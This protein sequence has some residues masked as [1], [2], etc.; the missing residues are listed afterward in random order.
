MTRHSQA[1]PDATYSGRRMGRRAALSALFGSTVEYFDFTLFAT[2]SALVFGTVFFAPL[3]PAG[4]LLAS[5]ATFGVAYVTRPLGAILFGTL[6]DRL[7]RKR[8][9]MMTLLAM[10]TAT[11]LIG[12][13][14]SFDTI[15]VAAPI[16]L[17]ILRLLQ[18]LS[19]GGEQAGSNALS[20]EHAPTAKRG[21]YTSWTMQGTTLGTLLASLSFLAV[22]APGVD[23]LLAWAWRIPFLMAGP[24]LLIVL[25]IRRGVDET[26]AF[27][28]AKKNQVVDKFPLTTVLR[29]HWKSVL[30]VIACSLLAVGGSTFAVYVL[31]YATGTV[32]IPAGTMLYVP[33]VVGVAGLLSQPLWA[34]LSDRVGRRVVFTGSMVATA[35][36]WLPYF[37]VVSTGNIPA[38]FIASFIFFGIVGTGANAVGASMYAESFPTAVRF[39]GVAIGTQL[40]FLVAGFAP[41]IEASLQGSGHFGWVPVGIF[42]AITALISA[43]AGWAGRET[44]GVSLEELDANQDRQ[45]SSSVNQDMRE[46][47][48]VP[49]PAPGDGRG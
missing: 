22:S 43:A 25:F 26:Q 1:H 7:G 23:V 4:G 34:A 44:R 47:G 38:I 19:A 18:G 15:G 6:G 3:G 42:A 32:K 36:G 27:K 39:T 35:L 9:L 49:L 40:G 29:Q 12:C 2:A 24:L 33:L 48:Q 31:G 16:I 17:V 13:I 37:W 20:L 41:A 8:T 30:R 10:G 21:L 45:N 28:E 14:P 11:F 46:R 5:F